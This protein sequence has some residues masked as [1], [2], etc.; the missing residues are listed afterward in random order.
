MKIEEV[1]TVEIFHPNTMQLREFLAFTEKEEALNE[2]R[3]W[4]DS[5]YEV[6]VKDNGEDIAV[7]G[8]DSEPADAL[9]GSDIEILWLD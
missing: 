5:I 8:I 3:T 2:A 9:E 1:Y 6:A 4:K 7:G